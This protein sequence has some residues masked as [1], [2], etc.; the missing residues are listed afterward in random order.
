MLS[1]AFED[2]DSYDRE[3]LYRP[4]CRLIPTLKVCENNQQSNKIDNADTEDK[5]KAPQ[6]V[7]KQL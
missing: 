7:D 5:E 6:E 3:S 1:S 2:T 4:S